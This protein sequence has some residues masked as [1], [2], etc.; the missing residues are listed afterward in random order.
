MRPN[1]KPLT[2]PTTSAGLDSSHVEALHEGFLAAWQ[3][4]CRAVERT[5]FVLGG[6]VALAHEGAEL[7]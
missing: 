3:H 1:K 6:R 7:R 5:P 2:A 4:L